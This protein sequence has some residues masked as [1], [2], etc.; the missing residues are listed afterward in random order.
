M[1]AQAVTVIICY[2][3]PVSDLWYYLGALL[4]MLSVLYGILD[5]LRSY[6]RLAM[7]RLPQF[8]KQGGDDRA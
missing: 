1:G 2:V 3:N 8:D 7:R 6:N 5:I 4:I